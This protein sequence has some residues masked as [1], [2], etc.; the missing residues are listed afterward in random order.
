MNQYETYF[1]YLWS[2]T[3]VTTCS[4]HDAIGFY[5]RMYK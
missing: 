2:A 3:V 1:N 4:V 5:V